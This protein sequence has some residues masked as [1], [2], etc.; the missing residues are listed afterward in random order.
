MRHRNVRKGLGLDYSEPESLFNWIIKEIDHGL[1]ESGGDFSA[2]QD[3][4]VGFCQSV[5]GETYT[6]EIKGM[7]ESVR[8]H[9]VTIAKSANAVGK[10][11]GA[12]RVA[13]WWYRCFPDCQV[14][15]GAAPPESNLKKLLW[16]E[17]NGLVEKH[18]EL[19]KSDIKTI[20]HIQKSAQ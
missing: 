20:L 12:A 13:V 17:I 2:Y 18:Q 8:D 7:M 16:G 9:P 3:D 1:D 19:F 14:Y 11:H 4:P 5:L 10:T 15:T 6:D